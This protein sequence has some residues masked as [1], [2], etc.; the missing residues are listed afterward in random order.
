MNYSYIFIVFYYIDSIIIIKSV[1]NA[2]IIYLLSYRM[3]IHINKF[4][5]VVINL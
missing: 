1:N 3:N 2:Y 4:I 5:I